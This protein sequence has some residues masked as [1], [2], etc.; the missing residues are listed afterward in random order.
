MPKI[1]EYT[2]PNEKITPSQAGF[3]AWETAGRRIGPLYGQIAA[4]IKEAGTLKAQQ[5]TDIGRWPFAILQLQKEQAA[6]EAA[7]Q[8]AAAK[9]GGGGVRIARAENIGPEQFPNLAALNELSQGAATLGKVTNNLINPSGPK[10]PLI[11]VDQGSGGVNPSVPGDGGAPSWSFGPGP[12][13]PSTPFNLGSEWGGEPIPT[14][15]N[16]SLLSSFA[17]WTGAAAA[18]PGISPEA[19]GAAAASTTPEGVAGMLGGTF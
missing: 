5:F 8:A 18:E 19:T 17:D 6:A 7:R 1:A 11:N 2:A 14:T 9:G 16:S 15:D 12:I 3:A 10:S 4:D 13:P